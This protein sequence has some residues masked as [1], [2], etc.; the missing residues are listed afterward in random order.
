VCNQGGD[1][2]LDQ[3][4]ERRISVRPNSLANLDE[5]PLDAH[6]PA[7]GLKICPDR[8][9]ESLDRIASGQ[10]DLLSRANL[11]D[12]PQLF[13][14]Q[15]KRLVEKQECPCLFLFWLIRGAHMFKRRLS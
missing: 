10:D 6:P 1:L 2:S 15:L 12:K 3:P 9:P 7:T 8:L 5:E 4:L 13:F 14:G 11:I